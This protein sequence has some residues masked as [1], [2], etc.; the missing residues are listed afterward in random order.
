VYKRQEEIL[1]H[2]W[3]IYRKL[4]RYSEMEG[5][6]LELHRRYPNSLFLFEILDQ[7]KSVKSP[8]HVAWNVST[9]AGISSTPYLDDQLTNR[10]QGEVRQQS[11]PHRFREHASL[12]LASKLDERLLHGFQANLGGEYAYK[13]FTSEADWG[14]GYEIPSTLVLN[15]GRQSILIDSNWNFSQG[16]FALGYSSTF[17]SG[18]NVGANASLFQLNKDWRVAGLSHTQSYFFDEFILMGYVDF[19]RHWIKSRED[20]SYSETGEYIG[21]IGLDGMYTFSA[22]LT[23]YWT[24]GRHAFGFGPNYYLAR[25]HFSGALSNG[26]PLANTD[27]VNTF[28]GTATYDFDLRRWLRFAVTGSCG[29]ELDKA[30][31][32]PGYTRKW[33]YSADAG[34][35]F[36]F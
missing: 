12:S 1:Y 32:N 28:S 11:G 8:S 9:R 2:L 20:S 24:L 31:W 3:T 30:S 23:P 25:S 16:H 13:G 33:V 15:E 35:S 4:E 21:K 17:Q 26:S 36:T 29:Y 14:A 10:V 22:S 5:L 34:V 27:W 18:W 19:Q 6:T 7:W